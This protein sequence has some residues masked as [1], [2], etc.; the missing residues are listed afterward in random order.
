M[1]KATKAT[2]AA[3]K[4]AK[5][6]AAKAKAA[7]AKAAA[8]VIPIESGADTPDISP[9]PETAAAVKLPYLK[10]ESLK[11]GRVFTRAQ[12]LSGRLTKAQDKKHSPDLVDALD[13]A[14]KAM[15]ALDEV[16]NALQDGDDGYA[17]GGKAGK[18]KAEIGSIVCLT[19]KG[20]KKYADLLEAEELVDLEVLKV[21]GSMLIV[22]SKASEEKFK[23]PRGLVKIQ[24]DTTDDDATD[25]D[26]TDDE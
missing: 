1:A 7:K 8:K 26:A 10:R 14:T 21:K 23:I 15:K 19:E 13:A 22:K 4:A 18:V 24:E 9:A 17:P 20:A 12:K 3:V 25:D 6:K 11:W 2:K 5:T 16:I